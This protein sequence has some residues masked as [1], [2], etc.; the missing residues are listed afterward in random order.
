[1]WQAVLWISGY[2]IW[3]ERNM[4]VF[5]G[6]ASSLNKIVQ[7]IQLKSFEWISRRVGKEK[8][9]LVL[10]SSQMYILC[11]VL[12]II[13]D[14]HASLK[15]SRLVV[16]SIHSFGR[17]FFRCKCLDQ[18]LRFGFAAFCWFDGK[19]GF[20]GHLQHNLHLN[21]SSS[22]RPFALRRLCQRLQQIVRFEVAVSASSA[23]SAAI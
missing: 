1:M 13:T 23:D 18:A 15:D 21:D 6:K 10:M 11:G 4:R 19:S 20:Y 12:W 16:Q 9:D 22:I 14:M 7:D 17:V 5:K 8:R 2:F 3:K